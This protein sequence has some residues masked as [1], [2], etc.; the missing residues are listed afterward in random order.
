[1][2]RPPVIHEGLDSTTDQSTDPDAELWKGILAKD[3]QAL[4][5]LMVRE[6]D[7]VS[8]FISRIMGGLGTESDVEEAIQDLWMSIWE[9]VEE[10]SPTRASFRAWINMKAKYIALDYRRKLLRD[11]IPGALNASGSRENEQT[12]LIPRVQSLEGLEAILPTPSCNV[13][14]TVETRL[15]VRMLFEA[16]MPLPPKERIAF[17]LRHLEGLTIKEIAQQMNL[18]PKAVEGYLYRARRVLRENLN[19]KL[20]FTKL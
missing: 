18:T 1:M 15:D 6:L 19:D 3:V 10:F 8:K 7:M 16:M 11:F 12:T 14:R 5:Q 20:S 4:E 9:G 17:N 2:G 13:E